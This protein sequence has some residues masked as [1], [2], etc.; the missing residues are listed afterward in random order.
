MSSKTNLT[1]LALALVILATLVEVV[2][3]REDQQQQSN[4]NLIKQQAVELTQLPDLALTNQ[5]TWLR[6][7]S[8]ATPHAIFPEDGTLLDYYQASFVYKI[9]LQ[10]SEPGVANRE[11]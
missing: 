5:A 6:H 2:I 3:L 11:P 7:R 4:Q 9:V 8:L 10:Q 1:L